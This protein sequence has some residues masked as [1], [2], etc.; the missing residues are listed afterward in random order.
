VGANESESNQADPFVGVQ[1]CR[2]E[3][4]ALFETETVDIFVLHFVKLFHVTTERRW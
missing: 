2:S 3:L 1:A 4:S